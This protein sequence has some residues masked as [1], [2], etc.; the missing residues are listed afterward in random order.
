M[1]SPTEIK[2]GKVPKGLVETLAYAEENKTAPMDVENVIPIADKQVVNAENLIPKEYVEPDIGTSETDLTDYT[3]GAS[4]VVESV[5]PKGTE[6]TA[7]DI[8]SSYNLKKLNALPG[9][10]VVNGKL[11]RVESIEP[12]GEVLT[13]SDILSSPNLQVLGAEAG[14]QIVN[15]KLKKSGRND[16]WTNFVNAYETKTAPVEEFG[17]YLDAKFP[18]DWFGETPEGTWEWMS[19]NERYG[20]DFENLPEKERLKV[21]TDERLKRIEEDYASFIPEKSAFS[22]GLG[23]FLG[24]FDVSALLP[25]KDLIKGS[26]LFG[27]AEE[28][29]ES[30]YEKGEIEPLETAKGAAYG[31]IG[32]KTIEKISPVAKKLLNKIKTPN[33]NKKA[34]KVLDKFEEATAKAM[35]TGSSKKEA[36]ELAKKE[37]NISDNTLVLAESKANRSANIPTDRDQANK[38]LDYQITNDLTIGRRINEGLSRVFIGTYERMLDISPVI[39]SRFL[40]FESKVHTRLGQDMVEHAPLFRVFKKAIP[41]SRKDELKYHLYN[42]DY[43]AAKALVKEYAPNS[44]KYIDELQNKLKQRFKEVKAAGR[45]NLGEIPDYFPRAVK[46]LRGLK[47]ALGSKQGSKIDDALKAVASSKD[48]KNANELPLDERAEIIDKVLRGWKINYVGKK[49]IMINPA[50]KSTGSRSSFTKG[51][52][53]EEVKPNLVKYYHDPETSLDMYFRSTIN[54]IEKRKLFGEASKNNKTGTL[55]SESSVGA[56]IAMEKEKGKLLDND[57]DKLESLIHSRFVGGEQTLNGIGR[58]LRDSGYAFTIANPG[59]AAVQ[60][61]ELAHSARK[62]GIRNTIKAMFQHKDID[63]VELGVKRRIEEDLI[64]PSKSARI[65]NKLFRYSGFSK[66][67][68]IGKETTIQAALNKFYKLAKTSKGR[69]QLKRKYGNFFGND[70]DSIITDLQNKEVT[71]RVKEMTFALLADLQPLSKLQQPELYNA[72]PAVRL[73]YMLKSF[74]IKQ[75]NIARNEV[76]KEWKAGNKVEAAKNATLLASYL[77]VANVATST[78]RDIMM[79]RDVDPEDLPNQSLWALT[80]VF[81]FNKYLSERYLQRGDLLGGTFSTLTPPSLQILL[82]TPKDVYRDLTEEDDDVKQSVRYIPIIG[83]LL[84]SHFFGGAEAYNER[85]KKD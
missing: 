76:Y 47:K 58:W 85:Q 9:D 69:E 50:A 40:N 2:E 42:S 22:Y 77:T 20:D 45:D 3:A 4:T 25:F 30:L 44:V 7:N 56:Y 13:G 32:G 81:G 70:M 62:Y 74:T 19:P 57:L 52:V 78:V 1:P 72:Y 54:D 73:L 10:R 66:I 38:I 79:G 37:L 48:L 71:P 24:E 59:S 46:D 65:L 33:T 36:I 64:D 29:A 16:W 43:K 14:D 61:A 23:E 82:N 83:P 21:M 6:L 51:R 18:L 60:L 63:A 75:W 34:N 84:Y 49:L 5:E 11:I 26:M 31:Y 53:L 27:A 41:S 55:D 39:A 17:T 12:E 28:T 15:G 35:A 67:D 8:R 80:S 68:A